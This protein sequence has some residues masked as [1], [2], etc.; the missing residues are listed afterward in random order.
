MG[1]KNPVVVMADAD[2]DLAV[3]STAQGAFGSTGQRCT[4]TSRVIVEDRIADAFVERLAARAAKVRVGNGLEGAEMGPA[5][6]EAQ[7][8]TDLRYVEIGSGEG[9]R[10]VQGGRRLTSGPFERGH[11]V[12]PTV[13]DHVTTSM[14]IAQEEIFGPVV[15]VMKARDF[16]DALD[17]ANGTEY[18]L[19]GSVFSRDPLRLAKARVEFMAGNLYLNRKCTGALVGVHPF[20]GFN[21]SGTDA[22]VGGPDYLLYFSQPKVVSIKHR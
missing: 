21:M 20:G 7:L 3:E 9:A 5:V 14:R 11:Y 4:A 18:G 12:E 16:D 2:L 17:I 10:L 1:G 8:T 13:F 22:K 15:A 19:T 6:D